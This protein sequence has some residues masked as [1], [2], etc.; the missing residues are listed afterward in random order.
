[1][2]K[3]KKGAPYPPMLLLSLFQALE[4]KLDRASVMRAR[5]FWINLPEERLGQK[6]VFLLK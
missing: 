5:R 1:M 3:N 4:H 6:N 2:N